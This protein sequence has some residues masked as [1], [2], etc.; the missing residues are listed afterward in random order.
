VVLGTSIILV[1]WWFVS[2]R[3]W[4]K[5]PHI[6]G[7]AA[8]LSEIERQVGETHHVDTSI[9]QGLAGGQ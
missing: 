7:S 9:E 6:Q 8:E 2:V 5:G 3:H 1:I 4:F